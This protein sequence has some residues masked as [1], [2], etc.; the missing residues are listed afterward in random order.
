MS[1]KVKKYSVNTGDK[2]YRPGETIPELDAKEQERL[3][4]LGVVEWT[5]D[6]IADPTQLG[7]SAPEAVSDDPLTVEEFAALSAQDQKDELKSL[8]IEPAS[9][10]EERVEQYKVWYEQAI[11]DSDE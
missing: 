2:V 6:V 8:E 5:N 9:K 1:V 10:A 11:T 3:L 4:A 7:N